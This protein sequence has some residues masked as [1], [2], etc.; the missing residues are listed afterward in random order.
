MEVKI[1]KPIIKWAGGKRQLLIELRKRL[2][3][4]FNRYFEPFLGAGALFFDLQPQ[5]A[6][7]NDFNHSLI[8]LYQS[9]RD[10]SVELKNELQ[11]LQDEFNSDLNKSEYYYKKRIRY[12]QIINKD[13]Y[14]E[15]ALFVFLNR[16][17]YNGLYRVNSKGEFNVPFGQKLKVDLMINRIDEIY[18]LL[19][20]SIITEGDFELACLEAKKG[21]F[22]YFDPPYYNTFVNYQADG[23]SKDEQLRLFRLFVK[24]SS[25]GVYCMLSNSN[26]DFIKEL[27]KDFNIEVV[28][29]K[30]LISR[31]AS[32][33]ISEEVIITNYEVNYDK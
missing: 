20:N 29:V 12:N 4:K 11:K 24:L 5:K 21:D 23:F 1:I 18:Q 26:N 28:S 9:C 16:T 31:N 8:N 7:I 6:F 13:S 32:L 3:K 15:A 22:V 27:Y 25:K 33:R 30:R 17:N 2:P 10:N 14:E 19:K